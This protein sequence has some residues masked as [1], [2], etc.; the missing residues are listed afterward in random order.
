MDALALTL[1][2]SDLGR[3]AEEVARERG[4]SGAI[5]VV[6]MAIRPG[7]RWEIDHA[8]DRPFYPASVMKL[9]TLGFVAHR[10]DE[11]LLPFTA[12]LERAARDMIRD[13][14]ND[15]T[16]YLIDLACNTTPGPELVDA[17]LEDFV[18]RRMAMNAFFANRFGLE[19]EVRNRTYNEGPYGREVQLMGGRRE[20]R[21]RLTARAA[22]HFMAAVVTGQGFSPARAEWMR[23]LLT[24]PHPGEVDPPVA[25]SADPQATDFLGAGTPLGSPFMS[26]AGWMSEVRH[27]VLGRVAADGTVEVVAVF[28]EIPDDHGLITALGRRLWG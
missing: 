17:A 26:K 18:R 22:A 16:G 11:G 12:E 28:T 19:V 25:D 3:L 21:N 15:A 14:N 23:S 4:Q 27:D 13:S 9:F 24:R 20:F 5:S 2:G 7:Q 6:A 8:G 1:T 10:L